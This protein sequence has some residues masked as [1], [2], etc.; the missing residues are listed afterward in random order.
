MGDKRRL[1][2]P[3]E[4]LKAAIGQR[5]PIAGVLRWAC[6]PVS[7]RDGKGIARETERRRE[8]TCQNG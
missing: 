1:S 2:T 6:R 7:D 4:I 3:D 8:Q 5:A